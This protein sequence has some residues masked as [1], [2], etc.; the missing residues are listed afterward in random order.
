MRRARWAAAGGRE[1]ARSGVGPR[2]GPRR[3]ARNRNA[4][5]LARLGRF[6][7]VRCPRATLGKRPHIDRDA[8]EAI[9]AAFARKLG[10]RAAT[11]LVAAG[12]TRG[13][14]G[15]GWGGSSLGFP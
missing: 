6:C 2:R 13:R 14:G 1:S 4:H 8:S 11:A 12:G 15:G 3:S 7:P 9:A 5:R 10:A